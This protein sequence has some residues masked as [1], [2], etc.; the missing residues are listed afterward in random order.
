MYHLELFL[1]ILKCAILV[2]FFFLLL[3][4]DISVVLSTEDYRET[5][6]RVAARSGAQFSLIP[7]VSSIFSSPNLTDKSQIGEIEADG[8][9][10]GNILNSGG[11][12]G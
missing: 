4:Q 12:D 1:F 11:I 2:N 9:L 3:Y 10:I 7:P 8:S 6:Q 5:M